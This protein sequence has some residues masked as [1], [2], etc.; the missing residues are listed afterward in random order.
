M[1]IASNIILRYWQE[2]VIPKRKGKLLLKSFGG[3]FF[4]FVAEFNYY[5]DD[6]RPTYKVKVSCLVPV[7]H[8]IFKDSKIRNSLPID[9]ALRRDNNIDIEIKIYKPHTIQL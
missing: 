3:G 8:P 6:N 2:K 7:E 5:I 1:E 9:I 4:Y